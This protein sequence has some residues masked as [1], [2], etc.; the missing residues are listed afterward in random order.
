MGVIRLLLALSVVAAHTGPYLGEYSLVGGS[1]AVEA[2]FVISGFYMALIL[3]E[4][5]KG[6]GSYRL[7]ISNRMLKLYPVYWSVGLI[8]LFLSLSSLIVLKKGASLTPYIQNYDSMSITSLIFL[9]VTNIIIFGQDA[10]MFLQLNHGDLAFT[11]D[12]TESSPMLFKFLLISPAWSLGTELLFY[13]IAPFIVRD[14]RKIVVLVFL[15]LI[16]KGY[17]LFGIGWNHDPWTYR[18]F[19]TELAF[20]LLG[21]CSYYFF[22]KLKDIGSSKMIMYGRGSFSIVILCTLIYEFAPIPEILK[23]NLYILIFVICIPFIFKWSSK[24]KI[25]RNLAELSY[26]VYISHLFI[27]SVISITG[28]N[29]NKMIFS[30]AVAVTS[31]IFSF[32]LIRFIVNPIEKYRQSRVQRQQKILNLTA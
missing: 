16:L 21:G 9:I 25:D 19:P 29:Q 12:F 13:S 30:L 31:V 14:I 17:I 20:F 2:F 6:R 32:I 8:T 27:I 24:N 4:K 3:N 15:S 23:Q 18:F 10:V 5:Y 11:S 1:T 22:L 28:L 7:F 26:P